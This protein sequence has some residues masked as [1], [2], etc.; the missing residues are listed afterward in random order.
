[1]D[2]NIVALEIFFLVLLGAAGIAIAA[3]MWAVISGL[4]RG[5]K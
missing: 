4:F 3:S 1:M 5:Q 2:I